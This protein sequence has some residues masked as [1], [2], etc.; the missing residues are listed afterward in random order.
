MSI[1]TIN[2][3]VATQTPATEVPQTPAA[4]APAPVIVK[5]NPKTAAAAL[6]E[7]TTLAVNPC[8]T[9]AYTCF[10]TKENS[11]LNWRKGIIWQITRYA[12]GINFEFRLYSAK[13]SAHLAEFKD[14]A[15]ALIAEG[16]TKVKLGLAS[17][18][19]IKLSDA[20]G[21]EKAVEKMVALVNVGEPIA[22]EIRAALKDEDFVSKKETKAAEKA[23]KEAAKLEAQKA[24]EALK[25]QQAEKAAQPPAEA[26]APS[27]EEKS[28]EQPVTEVKPQVVSKAAKKNGKK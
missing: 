10:T 27:T 6:V 21:E 28:A 26:P 8:G 12:T 15:D 23:K 16:M 24:A 22:Q 19:Y 13:Q 17:R 11:K 7:K 3:T 5:I 14:K 18:Y 20:D 25:A 4:P 2:E 9:E 1:E